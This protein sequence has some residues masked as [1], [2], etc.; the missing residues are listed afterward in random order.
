MDSESYKRLVRVARKKTSSNASRMSIR[1]VALDAVL[2]H[3][4]KGEQATSLG[5]VGR[6]I[7]VAIQEMRA[8]AQA[9]AT[10]AENRDQHA[11]SFEE[12][13]KTA[14]QAKW[15]LKVQREALGIADHSI[16]DQIYPI[17]Q[18]LR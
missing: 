1:E 9:W 7:E 17:P 6:R 10:S 11:L 15:E 2:A 18:K 12:A 4:L 13:R 3:D 14:L 16:L 8:C 5:R